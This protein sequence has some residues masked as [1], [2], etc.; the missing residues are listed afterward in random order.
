M[1]KLEIIIKLQDCAIRDLKKE[2]NHYKY[3][4]KI[5]TDYI[6]KHCCSGDCRKNENRKSRNKN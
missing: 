5:L 4:N 2:L 3:K 6:G 1:N